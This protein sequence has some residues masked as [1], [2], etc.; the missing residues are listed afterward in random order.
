MRIISDKVPA[1]MNYYNQRSDAN[2]WM[3]LFTNRGFCVT[4]N[5]NSTDQG[6]IDQLDFIL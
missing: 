2:A 5:F 1:S 3:I 6:Q 4:F